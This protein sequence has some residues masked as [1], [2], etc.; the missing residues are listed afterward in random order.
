VNKSSDVAHTA[1]AY[2]FLILK[3]ERKYLFG[4][5]DRIILK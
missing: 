4:D 5:V 3:P 1:N 2:K